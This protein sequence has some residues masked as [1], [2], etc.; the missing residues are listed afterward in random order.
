MN[1]H[2]MRHYCSSSS[3]MVRQLGSDVT[4][5]KLLKKGELWL[6][7]EALSQTDMDFTPRCVT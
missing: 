5:K 4:Q 1:L 2:R 6:K 3:T 7:V